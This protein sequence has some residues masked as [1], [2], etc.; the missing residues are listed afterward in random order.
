MDYFERLMNRLSKADNRTE[1]LI[2][3]CGLILFSIILIFAGAQSLPIIYG[4]ICC[5]VATSLLTVI[6]CLVFDV[7]WYSEMGV[8]ITGFSFLLCAPFVQ[9]SLKF[10]DKV[11]VPLVT[12]FSLAAISQIILNLAK[13]SNLPPYHYKTIIEVI[14]FV[15]GFL[16][17][18]KFKD[19]ITMFVTSLFG[20]YVSTMAGSIIMNEIPLRDLKY[21]NNRVSNS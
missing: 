10:S 12:G 21:R 20:G 17:A 5:L 16:I 9:L 18:L 8:G 3:G 19:S 15:L 13:V 4:I 14:C 11:S 2:I 6:L 1:A 7:A